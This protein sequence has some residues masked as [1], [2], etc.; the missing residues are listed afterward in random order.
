VADVLGFGAEM[1]LDPLNLVSGAGVMKAL[2]GRK[3]AK[4]TNKVVAAENAA[5]AGKYGYVNPKL[6]GQADELVNPKLAGQADEL[7]NPI[8]QQ[9]PQK[10]LGY[11]PERPTVYHGGHD[12]SA[13][14]TPEHPYGMFDLSRLKA[15][16]GANVYGPG[17]YFAD[18]ESTSERY[19]RI[20][21]RKLKRN[22]PFADLHREVNRRRQALKPD[23]W[24]ISPLLASLRGDPTPDSIKTVV[25][26]LDNNNWLGVDLSSPLAHDKLNDMLESG[27]G[28]DKQPI[29]DELKAAYDTL[30]V[31]VPRAK[32]YQ[33]D[34][35]H[36]FHEKL[37]NWEEPY[38]LQ[39]GPV[40]SGL[41]DSVPGLNEAIDEFADIRRKWGNAKTE[42]RRLYGYDSNFRDTPQGMRN[43][44]QSRQA[45][46]AEDE[47]VDEVIR[48]TGLSPY[49]V[50]N[51]LENAEQLSGEDIAGVLLRRDPSAAPIGNAAA[52][53]KLGVAG[54]RNRAMSTGGNTY[55][56]AIWDR[57]ML[58]Q[59][60]IR[61]IDGERVP[62]NPTT[63]VEQVERGKRVP[64]AA[65][66]PLT[67]T[68]NPMRPL[69]QLPGLAA[70]AAT[71]ALHNFTARQNNYGGIM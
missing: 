25:S 20:V 33:L 36:D 19:K 34:A 63:M 21:Q 51:L 28:L 16:E 15:G 55:N 47:L 2:K 22:D 13:S 67:P 4:A 9:A 60:R 43:E 68:M 11:T 65:D 27:L 45:F 69:Q 66:S 31:T 50:R 10:R 32:L 24:A 64:A 38:S 53:S 30:A 39:Y 58:D 40:Q 49:Q 56:Y 61:A 70:P 12:W 26:L 42:G 23:S 3:A 17:A 35:P 5:N 59:M 46:K 7:V 29:P 41:L 37:V 44:A 62:I 18:A 48:R 14:A 52:V 1:F 6:A 71:S 57:D 8:T 54:T